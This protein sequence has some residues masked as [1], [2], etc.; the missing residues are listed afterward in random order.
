MESIDQNHPFSFTA[1]KLALGT[2][3]CYIDFGNMYILPS[4]QLRYLN[5]RR[6]K[7]K[8]KELRKGN[9]NF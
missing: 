2:V 5:G 9:Q 1:L 7:M 6:K 4:W 3:P 8:T